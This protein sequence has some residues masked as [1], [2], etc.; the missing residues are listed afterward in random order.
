M[1][2]FILFIVLILLQSLGKSQTSTFITLNSGGSLCSVTVGS[3]GC[4]Y[5]FLNLCSN[6]GTARSIALD[7]NILYIV[8]TQGKLYKNIL[9]ATGTTS[10]C[11]LL[12]QFAQN[13]SAYYGMTVGPGGIVYAAINSDI[14]T[15]NPATNTFSVLGTLPNSWTIGGDLLFYQGKL[16]EAID[17]SGNNSLIQVDTNNVS[18]STLYMNFNA[19]SNVFGLSSVTVPCANNQVYAISNNGTNTDIY[20]VDMGNKTQASTAKCTL[21]FKVNDAASIAETQTANATTTVP[22]NFSSCSSVTYFGNTYTSNTSVKDTVKSSLGCDSIYHDVT[23]TINKPTSST[24]NL[25]NC[26]SVTYQSNTY[27]TSTILKD[28]VKSSLD[29]D[30]IYHDVVITIISANTVIN[31]IY[32][33]KQVIYKGNT[34]TNS[35]I[36]RDTVRSFDGGCDSIY[37]IVNINIKPITPTNINI[38]FTDCKQVIYKGNTYITSTVVR[39]TTKSYQG[40]DSVYTNA[41]I[42]IKPITLITNNVGFSHCNKVNYNGNNYYSSTVVR[43]T[44]RNIGGC[45]SVYNIA[46]ITITP[47]A[48]TVFPKYYTSCDSVLFRGVAYFNSTVIIDTIK[49]YQGCDS[50]YVQNIINILVKPTVSFNNASVYTLVNTPITLKPITTNASIYN[51][52]PKV[53]LDDSN[54]E[55]P[56]CY[57]LKDTS[58]K[59][60]VYSDSGC[61]DSSYIKV[62]VSKPIKVPTVFSPNGDGVNDKWE[63]ELLNSYHQNTVQIFDRGGQL[64]YSSFPGSYKPWNGKYNGKDLPVGVYYY[65]IRLSPMQEPIAGYVTILR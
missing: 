59:L 40:C 51:W 24:T 1:R 30:S 17:N 13:S 35:G 10:N 53:F 20:A 38:S 45:D 9:T 15:Y 42:T 18:A 31:N 25:S 55:Y 28:T 34:Y 4:S 16:Y 21:P 56:V 44:L 32:D 52:S 63:I 61:K 43:D 7:G 36:V 47:A 49:S 23:I 62:L 14:E 64:L 12:G 11:T 46:T 54:N 37:N 39:D 33:C 27:T 48:L 19:G 22:L 65:I 60:I 2:K 26:T 6:I 58:Y 8:N 41:T 5:T 50:V 3:S 29:C 57:P